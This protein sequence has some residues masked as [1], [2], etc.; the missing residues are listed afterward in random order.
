[1]STMDV[2]SISEQVSV[3]EKELTVKPTSQFNNMQQDG[4]AMIK[5]EYVISVAKNA[6]SEH[7]SPNDQLKLATGSGR[8]E[9]GPPSKRLKGQNK[10]RPREQR[11]P[12]HEK[13]CPAITND[14]VCQYG[15]KCCFSH[16]QQKYLSVKPEDIGMECYLY[17]TYGRCHFGVTC[18]FGGK[19][20]SPDGKNLINN[21][22]WLSFKD[23]DF[24]KNELTK[25]LQKLLWKRTYNFKQS[26][27]TLEEVNKLGTD[28]HE[29]DT[30][31]NASNANTEHSIEQ[32]SETPTGMVTDEDIIP[33]RP[34]EIKQINFRKKLYLSPLTTVGNLPFRRICK[35]LGA[36]VTCGEMA[37]CTNLLQGQQ[38]EWALLKRH[39]SEDT[40]GVQVCGAHPDTMIKCAQL[41]AEN[42]EIDFVD[43]NVGCPIDLIYHKGAGCGLMTR[44][45]KFEKIVTGMR[46]VLPVPLTAKIRTGVYENKNI[47]HH[48]IPKLKEWGVAMV[49]LHGRSR[50]Q[51]YTKNADWD[52]ISEC[53]KLVEPM[54]LF[55]NGDVLSYEDY[56]MRLETSG[57]SGI[58]IARGALIKPWI[59]TE[60][61]EQ[62]HWDISSSERFEIV[63]EYVNYGLEHW[64]A[65]NEGV[66][67]T[68]RFLLEWLSFLYRY[69]PVGLLERVP[70]KINERPPQY[71]GRDD[72]ETLMC[73]P[74]CVDWIKISEMLLGKVPEGF[75]FLP[76]HKANAYK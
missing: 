46:S 17:S 18:R 5:A 32:L 26:M 74:S 30:V 9:N 56:N 53:S 2:P 42:T 63:K 33:L 29:N 40:F 61:R 69:I 48:L 35:K 13:L 11:T 47:A 38:S 12:R 72:L 36:E 19:H 20:I 1:V 16:D 73:S 55:G 23:K 39:A 70:Q 62:R 4:V 10:S 75:T 43:I 28:D 57:V 21:E 52:Y 65:D 71:Q 58:L 34:S 51:R 14:R 44:T 37:L 68:R 25:P 27:Q 22:L 3:K 66:E 7:I 15:E 64:G 24:V 6:V 50:E 59:F 76:K 54:P 60:I 49:S 67:K 41:L 31:V 45:N 8:S